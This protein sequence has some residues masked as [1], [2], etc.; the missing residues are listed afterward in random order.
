MCKNFIW[1]SLPLFNIQS[2]L[3]CFS[4]FRLEK[5]QEFLSIH[6]YTQEITLSTSIFDTASD[7][8]WDEYTSW[9]KT[10]FFS[11]SKNRWR[12]RIVVIQ[13]LITY[14]KVLRSLFHWLQ[15]RRHIIYAIK[16]ISLLEKICLLKTLDSVSCL[17]VTHR[18]REDQTT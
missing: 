2:I 18:L 15:R 6:F 8:W 11:A 12:R 13:C 9:W 16:D 7:I 4:C 17:D 10:Y 5:F 3:E 1:L 14:I